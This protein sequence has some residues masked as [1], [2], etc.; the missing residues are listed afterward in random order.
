M[1]DLQKE[2]I[3]TEKT[4]SWGV[5]REYPC[6]CV[7][8]RYNKRFIGSGSSGFFVLKWCDAHYQERLKGITGR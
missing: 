8:H 6:G 4:L 3:Y 1:I 2:K 5:S 7:A